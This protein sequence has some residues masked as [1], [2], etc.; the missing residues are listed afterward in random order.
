MR[1]EELFRQFLLEQPAVAA[2][3]GARVHP[4][5]LPQASPLPALVY[6]E[7]EAFPDETTGGTSHIERRRYSLDI[8]G[9]TRAE[10]LRLQTILKNLLKGAS[11]GAQGLEIQGIFFVDETVRRDDATRTWVGE[12]DWDLMVDGPEDVGS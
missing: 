4:S 12:Q 5:E 7:R 11:A 6:E 10:V 2:L 9:R 1:V 8:H 3:V